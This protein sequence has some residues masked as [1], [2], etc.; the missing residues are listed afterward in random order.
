MAAKNTM[1]V[2]T[3]ALSVAF[4]TRGA[5][6]GSIGMNWG[7][8]SAQRL[9]PSM[10]VDLLL[11]NNISAA[12]VYT[13]Q[14]DILKAFAGSGIQLCVGIF[15]TSVVSS[16]DTA[17]QWVRT[18]SPYL[19]VSNVRYV[20]MGN[21]LFKD[22]LTNKTVMDTAITAMQNVQLALNEAGYGEQIKV[23][24][25]MTEAAFKFNMTKPSLAEFNEEMRAEINRTIDILRT[26][27]SPLFLEMFPISFV[28]ENTFLNPEFAFMDGKSSIVINDNGKIYTN[29]VEFLYD[30]YLWAMTKYGAG[31][32]EL[33]IGNVGWPTDGYPGANTSTAERFYKTFLPWVA[34]NRGTPM[35][36]GRSINAFLNSL[37]DENRMPY[38]YP[39]SRHW[40]IYTSY[41]DPKYKIDLSG[42]GRDIFPTTAKG[43]MRMPERWCVFDGNLTD[44]TLVNKH[45][46]FACSKADCTSLAPGG[47]CSQLTFMQNVSYAFN[48]YFQSKF[49]DEDACDFE[50]LGRVI[51]DNPTVGGCIFP[52]EVVKGQQDMGKNGGNQ[53]NRFTKTSVFFMSLFWALL[54]N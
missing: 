36:P 21:E 48:M 35:A 19:N 27:R 54:L 31:D 44:M 46:Q 38:K 45:F 32:I 26:N 14:E 25:G 49:Q 47:S 53:I 52:V 1:L 28:T 7:R 41:G 4:S 51:T 29:A 15:Q 42:Q 6:A 5:M 12:R 33:V 34:S 50:G 22:G 43:I 8:V 11:Q 3:L 16:I 37:A 30:S 10:V 39:F 17:R 9:I 2:L 40:G 24:I 18:R 23:T 13:S 20:V